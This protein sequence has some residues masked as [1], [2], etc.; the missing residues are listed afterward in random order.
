MKLIFIG[1]GN[2]GQA[3][4]N[5]IIENKILSEKNIFQYMKWMTLLKTRLLINIKL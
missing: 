1:A 2:M 3:I 5:G 4:I